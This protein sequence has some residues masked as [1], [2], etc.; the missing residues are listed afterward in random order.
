M[1]TDKAVLETHPQ[2]DKRWFKNRYVTQMER[3]FYHTLVARQ[4]SG[5]P[6]TQSQLDFVANIG[7]ILKHRGEI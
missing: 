7:A 6:I 3:A 5:S 4:T 1:N 2:R